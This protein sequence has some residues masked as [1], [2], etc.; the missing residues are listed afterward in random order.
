M[1]HN[2]REPACYK[3]RERLTN[4]TKPRSLKSRGFLATSETGSTTSKP[5][6]L[7]KCWVLQTRLQMPLLGTRKLHGRMQADPEVHRAF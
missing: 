5:A 1:N 2:N 3:L 7:T 4:N 6:L